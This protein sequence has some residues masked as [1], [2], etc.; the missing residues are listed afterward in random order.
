MREP[1]PGVLS[2]AFSSSDFSHPIENRYTTNKQRLPESVVEDMRSAYARS[3]EFLQTKVN[4]ETSEE[5]LASAFR[6]QL[7]MVAGFK[8]DEI[9]KM[10][11]PT[12][13]DEDL[14]ETV[15]KLLLGVKAENGHKQK[16]VSVD[17]AN[18]YLSKGWEFVAKLSENKVV[19][20][21]NL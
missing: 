1:F 20:K 11:L 8:Q 21:L 12:L 2:G 3:E 17:E 19:I 7:L 5:K 9:E 16:V 13:S 15:R 10:D 14:Q 18:D 4:A 6:K